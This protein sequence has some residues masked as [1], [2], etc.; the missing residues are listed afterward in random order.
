MIEGASHVKLSEAAVLKPE[1]TATLEQQL[2]DKQIIEK[3][4]SFIKGHF[5]KLSADDINELAQETLVKALQSARR[6]SAFRGDS[7]L[8][9]WLYSIAFNEARGGFRK[10][11]HRRPTESLDEL[12]A[13]RGDRADLASSQPS[14]YDRLEGKDEA[15][16]L[17]RLLARLT[18]KKREALEL[19]IREEGDIKDEELAKELEIPVATARTRL[20]YARKELAKLL[21]AQKGAEA[22]KGGLAKAA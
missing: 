8:T 14:S 15:R 16:R 12:L 5:P 19:L 17:A 6:G 21:A 7:K 13:T 18:P 3:L 1:T 10:Q 9:T 4:K 22:K 20:H 11:A 2:A